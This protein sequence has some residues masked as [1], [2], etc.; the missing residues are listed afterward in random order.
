LTIRHRN[1]FDGGVERHRRLERR[2]AVVW[3]LCLDRRPEH[4][5]VGVLDHGPQI[6][7]SASVRKRQ[8]HDQRPRVISAFILGQ[9]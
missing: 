7:S 1:V 6:A 4:T 3:E 2:T 8:V 5:I 9:L